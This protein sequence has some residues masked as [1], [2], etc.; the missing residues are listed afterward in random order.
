MGTSLQLG[1]R[2]VRVRPI[3]VDFLASVLAGNALSANDVAVPLKEADGSALLRGG[4]F[5]RERKA[6]KRAIGERAA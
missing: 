3:A 6:M 2:D 1:S 4:D 5:Q